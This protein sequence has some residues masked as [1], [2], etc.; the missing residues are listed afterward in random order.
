MVATVFPST[1]NQSVTWNIV[2]VTGSATINS[3]GLVTAVSN[4][5][6]YAKATA[7]QDITVKDSMMV[8]M[9]GQTGQPPDVITLAANNISSSGATLNGTV[10]ANNLSTDV[11]FDW[12]LTS[13]YG[14]TISATPPSVIGNVATPVL[15]NL[16]NLQSSTTYHF[17]V[18]GINAAGTATGADLTLKT[19][20]GVG[21]PEN[22]P[23]QMNIYP[24]PNKGIFNISIR[25]GT[26]KTYALEVYDNLGIKVYNSRNIQ[27]QEGGTKTIDIRPVPSGVY[28]VILSG[29]V[30]RVVRKIPVY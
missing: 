6:V 4:G 28:T 25:N 10:N 20:A 29:D 19:D 5:T 27:V 9:S 23:L 24:V 7:V 1:A 8:T 18:R 15:A 11:F 17:R 12:G 21:V 22:D 30:E 3:T 26:G 14:N 13:A 2:P 16:T